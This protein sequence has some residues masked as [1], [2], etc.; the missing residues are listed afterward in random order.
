M[1]LSRGIQNSLI[2]RDRENG[3][4]FMVANQPATSRKMSSMVPQPQP[5]KCFI[6]QVVEYGDTNWER[7][8]RSRYYMYAV[9][10]SQLFLECD[11]LAAQLYLTWSLASR[12]L[13]RQTC[14]SASLCKCD[15]KL[16]EEE[17]WVLDLFK[18]VKGSQEFAG[19]SSKLMAGLATCGTKLPFGSGVGATD[20][21]RAP[22]ETWPIPDEL[23]SL[24]LHAKDPDSEAYKVLGRGESQ[25]SDFQAHVVDCWP[26]YEQGHVGLANPHPPSTSTRVS[27][28]TGSGVSTTHMW[29]G[30]RSL[31]AGEV[32][33]TLKRYQKTLA[34]LEEHSLRHFREAARPDDRSKA[35]WECMRQNDDERHRREKGEL[36]GVQTFTYK[37]PPLSSHLGPLYQSMRFT[38]IRTR[39]QTRP[40]ALNAIQLC[41]WF[42][43]ELIPVVGTKSCPNMSAEHIS[44][45]DALLVP[46]KEGSLRVRTGLQLMRPLKHHWCGSEIRP[47]PPCDLQ[48]GDPGQVN[49]V[50]LP[51]ELCAT[52]LSL[53]GI[54]F[55]YRY[56]VGYP[57]REVEGMGDP[58]FEV[59]L[60]ELD[61]GAD[62]QQ[63]D[64]RSHVLYRSAEL[65][66]RY[67][68]D[69]PEG[70]QSNYSP[71]VYVRETAS[72]GSLGGVKQQLRLVF[73]NQ[74]KTF[75]LQG[76]MWTY[77][78]P[79]FELDHFCHHTWCARQCELQMQ[80]HFGSASLPPIPPPRPL[81]GHLCYGA[82]IRLRSASTTKLVMWGSEWC[83]PKRW[84]R[85]VAAA[86]HA[87]DPREEHMWE[88]LPA[89]PTDIV[90]EGEPLPDGALIR[91]ENANT[92]RVLCSANEAHHNG[93]A[94]LFCA[95]A[96][97]MSD[98]KLCQWRVCWEGDELRL[99]HAHSKKYLA[100]DGQRYPDW[101]HGA[102]EVYL[103]EAM[104]GSTLWQLD[105]SLVPGVLG[106]TGGQWVVDEQSRVTHVK[107]PWPRSQQGKS[108]PYALLEKG[109]R[110]NMWQYGSHLDTIQHRKRCAAV[111]E[112]QF[113]Q[114]TPVNAYSFGIG[115]LDGVD[116]GDR[117]DGAPV[118][119][120]VEGTVDGKNWEVV[121]QVDVPHW[122]LMH[123]HDH[124]MWQLRYPYETVFELTHTQPST[125]SRFDGRK[126]GMLN[127][128][129]H[130]LM[131]SWACDANSKHA[132]G[133]Y[134]LGWCFAYELLTGKVNLSEWTSK[135]ASAEAARLWL[136]HRYW[137][138]WGNDTHQ[139]GGVDG[140]WLQVLMVVLDHPDEKWPSLPLQKLPPNRTGSEWQIIRN[141]KQDPRRESRSGWN[142]RDSL[143]HAGQFT[144]SD[145][146]RRESLYSK[147]M[148]PFL[149]ALLTLVEKV[150]ETP[151]KIWKHLHGT[152]A[153]PST[154]IKDGHKKVVLD[155]RKAAEGFARSF[156]PLATLSDR[157]VR[158]WPLQ[159]PWAPAHVDSRTVVSF[160]QQELAATT[161][162]LI[163]DL[164]GLA[165]LIS[166]TQMAP[167]SSEVPFDVSA[168]KGASTA[169][170]TTNL[171]RLAT[172]LQEYAK[173][174]A[175]ETLPSL[176]CL[177]AKSLGHGGSTTTKAAKAAV[178]VLLTLQEALEKAQLE[179]SQLM[180]AGLVELRAITQQPYAHATERSDEEFDVQ[181]MRL[182]QHMSEEVRDRPCSNPRRLPPP[183]P[184]EGIRSHPRDL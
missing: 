182:Q 156:V 32:S 74:S 94:Q 161:S 83:F 98:V 142:E 171:G 132:G 173:Q 93:R 49:V 11:S 168:A 134:G 12:N 46:P 119:W 50:V 13:F 123:G 106:H 85:I 33:S 19:I 130:E 126:E 172:D 107:P 26:A 149:T 88:V 71:P 56:V 60:V 65:D 127:T 16:T 73:Y 141:Q 89:D 146:L 150:C 101:G 111:L 135:G 109:N 184:H 30:I 170:A 91:L 21:R 148:Q 38:F 137:W 108:D 69:P 17:A 147:R 2:L 41:R 97:H 68:W 176:K 165:E 8:F 70:H 179:N 40:V 87:D 47:T 48:S 25:L 151:G 144:T 115:S 82:Q 118:A 39:G 96:A 159:P 120:I 169:I 61:Q 28:L 145:Y 84:E 24:L 105:I 162:G 99:Q 90:V 178:S 45:A 143:E 20:I 34:E 154:L 133:S 110:R 138:C 14:R 95:T 67:G 4:H 63:D 59:V 100:V 158:Q 166:S 52:G 160:S 37:R 157:S 114:P 18:T 153:D 86:E 42:A 29:R 5:K 64:L 181:L 164:P 81:D 10:T 66:P 72:I 9:H 92:C 79:K 129:D 76:A 140:F 75:N 62:E 6:S 174:V 136:I 77:K 139:Q 183:S 80:L 152:P 163:N 15:R 131:C 103:S 124:R 112:I 78:S 180:I 102:F 3:F 155:M 116:S 175:G 57:K 177:N 51:D 43:G 128:Y 27:A 113:S 55:A 121:H 54:S 117:V 125:I 35:E 7:L 53:C 23:R 31:S 104:D 44:T 58:Y 22:V 1:E 167:V 36:R 122:R